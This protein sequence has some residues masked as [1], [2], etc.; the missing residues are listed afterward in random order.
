[1]QMMNKQGVYMARLTTLQTITFSGTRRKDAPLIRMFWHFVTFG[2]WGERYHYSHVPM[3]RYFTVMDK[4]L[5]I[6]IQANTRPFMQAMKGI[7][8][9]NCRC[10]MVEVIKEQTN[11]KD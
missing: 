8:L 3:K 2:N 4:R 9:I 10:A 6:N 7:D 1:M 5:T 11:K